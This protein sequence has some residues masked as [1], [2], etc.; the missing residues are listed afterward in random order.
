MSGTKK[1]GFFAFEEVPLWQQ[2]RVVGPFLSVIA[3]V[4]VFVKIIKEHFGL[5]LVA[6]VA[7]FLGTM[8]T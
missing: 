2:S 4:A 3:S 1:L 6:V 5:F 8:A 7:L